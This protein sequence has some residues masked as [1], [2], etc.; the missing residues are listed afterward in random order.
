VL[1]TPAR[2]LTPEAHVES[3]R[4]IGRVA[5]RTPRRTLFVASADQSHTH[6]AD[7]PYGGDPAAEEFDQLVVEAIRANDLGALRTVP[8]TLIEAAKPDA[9]W[10]LL[11]LDGVLDATA[12]QQWRSELLAYEAPTYY[13]MATALFTPERSEAASAA[14]G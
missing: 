12:A 14:T 8:A 10:Q 7:G 5:A 2:D 1:L 4:V 9:W 13:G 6:A 3:G 11:M